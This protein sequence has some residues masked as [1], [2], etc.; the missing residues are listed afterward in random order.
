M[1]RPF[2]RAAC[3][4]ALVAAAPASAACVQPPISQPDI[5]SFLSN[6]QAILTPG[7]RA[8][9]L[10]KQIRNLAGSDASTVSPIFGLIIASTQPQRIAIAIGL[11]QARLA[12]KTMDTAIG[13]AIDKGVTSIADIVFLNAYYQVIAGTTGNRG[14]FG[15][16]GSGSGGTVMNTPQR[17]AN[18]SVFTPTSPRTEPSVFNDF[19]ITQSVNNPGSSKPVSAGR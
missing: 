9:G 16:P 17:T 6:P 19:S 13:D 1:F 3:L 8:P 4:L 14:D 18:E 12:C 2:V 11:G 10:A 5:Q 7:R 15:G